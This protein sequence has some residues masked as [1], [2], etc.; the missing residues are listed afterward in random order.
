ME[1]RQLALMEVARAGGSAARAGGDGGSGDGGP[2][3]VAAASE[4]PE[5]TDNLAGQRVRR[6][7]GP[8]RVVQQ[9]GA[10]VLRHTGPGRDER[11]LARQ[12]RHDGLRN[13]HRGQRQRVRPRPA[14]A[15][16]PPAAAQRGRGLP[17]AAGHRPARLP[18]P[19]RERTGGRRRCARPRPRLRLRP[20]LDSLAIRLV[21]GG[22]SRSGHG[23]F[24]FTPHTYVVRSH[25]L[26]TPS[27]SSIILL[28]NRCGVELIDFV[29]CALSPRRLAARYR[30]LDCTLSYA[31]P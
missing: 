18:V 19:G 23:D 9:H 5:R 20:L 6:A 12:R 16:A 30:L 24:D 10:R 13:E 21:D 31:Y 7:D 2:L 17:P 8:G 27:G 25:T 3:A 15:A 26:H 4:Q 1:L 11:A 28:S 22:R 14:A 29:L